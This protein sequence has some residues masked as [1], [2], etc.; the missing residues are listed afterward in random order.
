MGEPLEERYLF[1]E[2][3]VH[4]AVATLATALSNVA[5]VGFFL[6][7]Y[8][9]LGEGTAVSLRPRYFTSG[10]W[11]PSSLWGWLRLW[12]PPWAMPPTW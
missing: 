10:L 3:P 7:V 1:E 11:G 2:M 12:P 9:R 5:S 6:V 4:K 8:R